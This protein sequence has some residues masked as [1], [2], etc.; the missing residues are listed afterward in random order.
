[1]EEV[2]EDVV[3]NPMRLGVS[4]NHRTD[5]ERETDVNQFKR[6]TTE[7][8]GGEV[9]FGMTR[10]ELGQQPVRIIRPVGDPDEDVFEVEFFNIGFA[11][12]DGCDLHPHP[13]ARATNAE[14]MAWLVESA[15]PNPLMQG[16]VPEAVAKYAEFC[17]AKPEKFAD[18][19]QSVVNG[20]AWLGV[21][22]EALDAIT[23]NYKS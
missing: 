2:V 23:A 16:F 15:S 19:K 12:V 17:L 21:A 5:A 14:F 4:A 7:F 20:K 22:Q 6:K 13:D 11:K 3:D 1:M 9:K 8:Q 18:D 10:R